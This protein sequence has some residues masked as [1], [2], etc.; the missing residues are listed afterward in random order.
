MI[1]GTNSIFLIVLGLFCL[2]SILLSAFLY[3]KR[4]FQTS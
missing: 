3:F 4:F 1:P 2:F